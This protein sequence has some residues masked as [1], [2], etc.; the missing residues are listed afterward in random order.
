MFQKIK[1]WYEQGFWT[2]LM[3]AN[4]VVKNKITAEQY[5]QITGEIYSEE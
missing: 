5:E 1:K 3:V 4:A 2:K